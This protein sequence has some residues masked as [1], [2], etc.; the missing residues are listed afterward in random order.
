M[1]RWPWVT[2]FVVL[3]ACRHVHGACAQTPPQGARSPFANP[4]HWRGSKRTRFDRHPR[5]VKRLS[6]ATKAFGSFASMFN[7]YDAC[8]NG[9]P[10]RE[11][12][13]KPRVWLTK[14]MKAV[15]IPLG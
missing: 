14:G 8:E 15:F 7:Y 10:V 2:C 1:E 3:L 9:L 6:Q 5:V 4:N 12:H 11:R 13:T